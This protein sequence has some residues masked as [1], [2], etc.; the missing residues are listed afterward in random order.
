MLFPPSFVYL[1][2]YFLT[3]MFGL[4]RQ[5]WSLL[6]RPD[7]SPQYVVH[8][9]SLDL[10]FHLTKEH[11]LASAKTKPRSQT[12]NQKPSTLHFFSFIRLTFLLWGELSSWLQSVHWRNIW[13]I[14]SLFS[15]NS[16]SSKLSDSL[17]NFPWYK[18]QIAS[19]QC[20]QATALSSLSPRWD[21]TAT[22]NCD[23]LLSLEL[24]SPSQR[25]PQRTRPGGAMTCGKAQYHLLFHAFVL[26]GESPGPVRDMQLCC[27]CRWTLTWP[28]PR[29]A[30]IWFNRPAGG[31]KFWSMR[32]SL[33]L[34]G[35]NW[36]CW[37]WWSQVVPHWVTRD[38]TNALKPKW[39]EDLTA[40]AMLRRQG[41]FEE[42]L[43]KHKTSASDSLRPDV[44]RNACRNSVYGRKEK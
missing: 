42:N 4:I 11:F 23:E 20:L 35:P 38:H 15:Q 19:A 36:K 1:K 16:I 37:L 43:N 18:W 33:R 40:P 5:S 14:S 10:H 25:G 7:S 31:K 32:P 34:G 24:F 26:S 3:R 28:W 6:S 44:L 29:G 22:S 39:L 27:P 9:C 8:V 2:S 41:D 12:I 17:Q 13:V 21:G 30:P